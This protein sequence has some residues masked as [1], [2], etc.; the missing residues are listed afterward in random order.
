MVSGCSE[1]DVMMRTLKYVLPKDGSSLRIPCVSCLFPV[2]HAAGIDHNKDLCVWA[3]VEEPNLSEKDN[4]NGDY[5]E[6]A[7]FSTGEE[8]PFEW[9]P[10]A[11]VFDLPY[12]WHVKYRY[13]FSGENPVTNTRG[14]NK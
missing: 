12:V 4:A 8:F 14:E 1:E 11:T 10:V 5:V 13:R 2:P 6:V 7:V 3:D 9:H